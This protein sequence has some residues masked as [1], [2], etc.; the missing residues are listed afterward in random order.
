MRDDEALTLSA[1][2]RS[3]KNAEHE[4]SR[5]FRAMRR[6]RWFLGRLASS[7]EQFLDWKGHYLFQFG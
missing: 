6:G 2:L 3:F 5:S 7:A 4:H 1:V